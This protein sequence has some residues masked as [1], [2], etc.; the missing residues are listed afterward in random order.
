[1]KYAGPLSLQLFVKVGVL[2]PDSVDF[3]LERDKVQAAS[4]A[5]V[6]HTEFWLMVADYRQREF[7][8]EL[9]LVAP[10]EAGR[11]HIPARKSLQ[12]SVIPYLPA[13]RLLAAYSARLMQLRDVG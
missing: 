4:H 6:D 12:L 2:D 13:A 5:V 1:M 3:E 11:L 7:W 9:E 8:E 10:H